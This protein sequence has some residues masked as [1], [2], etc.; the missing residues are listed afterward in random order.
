MLTAAGRGRTGPQFNL[1]PGRLN[2]CPLKCFPRPQMYQAL[3]RL[4]PSSLGSGD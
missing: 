3:G 2:P 4:A 1:N